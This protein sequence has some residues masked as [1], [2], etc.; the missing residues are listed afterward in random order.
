VAQTIDFF[1]KKPVPSKVQ[2]AGVTSATGA[3]SK[4]PLAFPQYVAGY[5]ASKDPR[6]SILS[7]EE[8]QFF[9]DTFTQSGFTG[10]IN[11]YRNYTRNWEREASLDYTIRVPCLMVMAELDVVLPPSAADGMEKLIPDLEKYLIEGSGHWTQQEKPQELSAK[12]MEWYQ[13]RF[14]A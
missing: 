5:D 2:Q 3:P 14:T 11:W 4:L 1:M 9:I 6:Q 8:R 10:G 13:R 7:T 12:I